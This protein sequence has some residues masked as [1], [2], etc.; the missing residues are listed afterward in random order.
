MEEVHLLDTQIIPIIE[1]IPSFEKRVCP[2]T[3]LF[4]SIRLIRS[5]YKCVSVLS[6]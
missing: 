4:R 5:P 3:E 6:W 1:M 2:P